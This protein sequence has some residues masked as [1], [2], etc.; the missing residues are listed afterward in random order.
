MDKETL[1]FFLLLLVVAVLN[2][3]GIALL[4]L[5]LAPKVGYFGQRFDW[6]VAAIFFPY[7]G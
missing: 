7:A 3:S 2:V 1:G 5:Y 4:Y 6:I